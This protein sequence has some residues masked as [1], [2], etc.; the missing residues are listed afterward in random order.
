M[1]AKCLPIVFRLSFSPSASWLTPVFSHFVL[2]GK[3]FSPGS[4]VWETSKI[5]REHRSNQNFSLIYIWAPYILIKIKLWW[6][7]LAQWTWR[8]SPRQR[9]DAAILLLLFMWVCQTT[10]ATCTGTTVCCHFCAFT[11]GCLLF[12]QLLPH[13]LTQ[14]RGTF[15]KSFPHVFLWDNP[16]CYW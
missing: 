9:R 13:L 10:D 6:K 3:L 12:V 5:S 15:N 16:S 2:H 7:Q 14:N 4:C 1:I 11:T 8:S